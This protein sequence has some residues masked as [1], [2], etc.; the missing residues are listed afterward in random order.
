ML[1]LWILFAH[2]LGDYHFQSRWLATEKRKR[3][4]LL[5]IHSFLCAMPIS[6]ILQYHKMFEFIDLI[7]LVCVHMLIDHLKGRGWIND[8]LDHVFHIISLLILYVGCMARIT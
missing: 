4:Y 2:Y 7:Y 8:T 5:F 3:L 6:G 1:L